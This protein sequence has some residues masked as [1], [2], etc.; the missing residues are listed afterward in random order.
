MCELKGVMLSGIWM[1]EKGEALVLVEMLLAQSWVFLHSC[2][3]RVHRRM[4]GW[5]WNATRGRP[6]CSRHV[7]FSNFSCLGSRP[8]PPPAPSIGSQWSW[9]RE[10][11]SFAGSLDCRGQYLAIVHTG[12]CSSGHRTPLC[13]QNNLWSRGLTND[14]SRGTSILE[15]GSRVGPQTREREFLRQTITHFHESLEADI[16]D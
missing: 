13:F 8:P 6:S 11:T 4:V 1:W 7:R 15:G 5:I 10:L 14:I 3:C 2:Q 9:R 16:V 12:P